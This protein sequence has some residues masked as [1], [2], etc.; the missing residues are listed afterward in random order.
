LFTHEGRVITHRQLMEF[1]VVAHRL[2]ETNHALAT[3]GWYGARS[4]LLTPRQALLRLGV[5]D[6]ALNRLDVSTELDGV[7]EGIWS[8]TQLEAQGVRVLNRPP[9]LL[10]CH[11]QLLAARLLA[12]HG[13]PHPRTRRR[14]SAASGD[15]LR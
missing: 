2:T 12:A 6:V 5:G 3:R 8:I 13:V 9:A 11:D 10:A 7:E 1:A 15:G 4:H 14:E